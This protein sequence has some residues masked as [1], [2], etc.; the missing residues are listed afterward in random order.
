MTLTP[1]EWRKL[2]VWAAE[3]DTSMQQIVGEIV[4]HELDRRP[5]LSF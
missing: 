3:D 2:R 4:R 1:D 5:R